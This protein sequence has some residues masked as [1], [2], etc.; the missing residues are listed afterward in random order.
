[1]LH[2][3][4]LK[5]LLILVGIPFLDGFAI[6]LYFVNGYLFGKGDIFFWCACAHNLYC[7][8]K[9]TAEEGGISKFSFWL[10]NRMIFNSMGIDISK[11]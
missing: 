4:L 3:F 8:G 1:M 11:K 7:K 5:V 2:I 6:D 10:P 9:K